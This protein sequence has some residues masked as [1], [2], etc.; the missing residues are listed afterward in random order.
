M[1]EG[2][3]KSSIYRFRRGYLI[4]RVGVCVCVCVCVCVDR[5]CSWLVFVLIEYAR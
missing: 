1:K 2:E 4:G 5:E 3:C